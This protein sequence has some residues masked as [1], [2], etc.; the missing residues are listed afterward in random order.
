MGEPNWRPAASDANLQ[1]V[2]GRHGQL[3]ALVPVQM[4][5]Q[6]PALSL[7]QGKEWGGALPIH[8]VFIDVPLPTQ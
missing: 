2:L 5:M 3:L 7:R 4:N 1:A 6:T 8:P